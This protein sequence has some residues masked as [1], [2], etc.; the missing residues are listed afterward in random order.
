MVTADFD[1]TKGTECKTTLKAALEAGR[2]GKNPV[3]GISDPMMQDDVIRTAPAVL[4]RREMKACMDHASDCTNPIADTCKI[5]KQDARKKEA[6]V[7]GEKRCGDGAA[8]TRTC[9][10]SVLAD[11]RAKD[12]AVA[13]AAGG[14][15]GATTMMTCMANAATDAQVRACK[16]LAGAA[17]AAATGTT[18]CTAREATTCKA[19]A[20]ALTACA[21]DTPAAIELAVSEAAVGNVG[22]FMKDCD[23]TDA[24]KILK[25]DVDAKASYLKEAGILAAEFDDTKWRL[26]KKSAA[27]TAMNGY[28][29]T[30][31]EAAADTNAARATCV[32]AADL[33]G[34]KA[35]GVT[36]SA[37][38]K[39][40]DQQKAAID[41]L[42]T[43]TKECFSP[44]D[45]AVLTSAEKKMCLGDRAKAVI[46]TATG[47]D[48]TV[49]TPTDVELYLEEAKIAGVR[50][51]INACITAAATAD[52]SA[53]EECMNAPVAAAL[54]EQTGIAAG[55]ITPQVIAKARGDARHTEMATGVAACIDALTS[56]TAATRKNCKNEVGKE[57]F[58][59][60]SGKP[61]DYVVPATVLAAEI[62][63]AAKP[64]VVDALVLC[65]KQATTAAAKRGCK[66]SN[67]KEALGGATGKRPDDIQAFEL[68]AVVDKAASEK[69]GDAN[70]ACMKTASTGAHRTVC[71]AAQ[72]VALADATG[73]D[74]TAITKE[75]VA[76]FAATAAVDAIKDANTGC[77][78]AANALT[79]G[80]PAKTTAK[81]ACFT[82]AKEA[83][84][85]AKGMA[86]PADGAG[87]ARGGDV[88]DAV[89]FQ[90]SR[91]QAAA[92]TVAD[93]AK[94]C[95]DAG[96]DGATACAPST[97]LAS[98]VNAAKKSYGP[99]S[100]GTD[101]LLVDTTTTAGKT[102]AQ[103]VVVKAA[104][105]MFKTAL[106]ACKGEKSD[107]TTPTVSAIKTCVTTATTEAGY[108]TLE[109]MATGKPAGTG[110]KRKAL[111]L[112]KAARFAV[113]EHMIDCVKGSAES[114]SAVK[115]TKCKEKVITYAKT[116]EDEATITTPWLKKTFRG[117]RAKMHR[118][119]KKCDSPADCKAALASTAGEAGDAASDL[120]NL[121]GKPSLVKVEGKLAAIDAAIEAHASCL[122]AGESLEKCKP[123]TK[124]AFK[125][126][127][128][129]PDITDAKY[130]EMYEPQI[131]EV[132]TKLRNGD[133]VEPTPKLS[134]D[135]T[136][137]DPRACATTRDTEI[138]TLVK[139]LCVKNDEKCAVSKIETVVESASSCTYWYKLKDIC[140]TDATC[141]SKA[142]IL[143][144][145]TITTTRRRLLATTTTTSAQTTD[146]STAPTPAPVGGSTAPVSGATSGTVA[147][148]GVA[149][150][151]L[152]AAL[153]A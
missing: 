33:I 142:D 80:N 131:T 14:G 66:F 136:V 98:I 8:G 153:L 19:S 65:A 87:G 12:A 114:T 21:C 10:D 68:N 67:A 90:K 7:V 116:F 139:A 26:V 110:P 113:C 45:G 128:G 94:N 137:T 108:D 13:A 76:R 97:L 57:M 122:D 39:R 54:A 127:G 17:I 129:N 118:D 138:E 4:L 50:G 149:F 31:M 84:A 61:A 120:N 143:A 20:A 1:T 29:T 152:A 151:A 25:C 69:L 11:Q 126:S 22:Q 82:A 112:K 130:A 72:A 78:D 58:I 48:A 36:R 119:A 81:V 59:T 64:V 28:M 132:A 16:V 37:D 35:L 121:G 105:Q 40:D 43:A 100:T 15:A 135:F 123:I 91:V 2:D 18:A 109:T 83:A 75:T 134:I 34:D 51:A 42:R 106:F 117:C 77:M 115:I 104:T 62:A 63:A 101:A 95:K 32:T 147:I 41:A 55:D 124:E 52:A 103:E 5:C 38:Q 96:D 30:C 23:R 53:K 141:E 24:A 150:A 27:A 44:T 111:A 73:M 102:A 3:P 9:D 125:S 60:M 92:L 133:D 47:L 56:D 49:V 6:Q 74:S 93:L 107:G 99:S 145:G 148:T 144:A 71:R 46:A 140:T 70:K 89:D 85:E 88:F 86:L 79:T 146:Y